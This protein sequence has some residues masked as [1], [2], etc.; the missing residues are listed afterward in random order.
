MI[1]GNDKIVTVTFIARGDTTPSDPTAVTFTVKD[2]A[3][4]STTYTY[5][6]LETDTYD[7]LRVS[8]GV[9]ELRVACPLAGLYYVTGHGT[10]D[11]KA[12]AGVSFKVDPDRSL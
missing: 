1:Q 11:V 2:P 5:S 12:S 10:G 3:N 7:V 6:A 8:A 4:T 9:Y